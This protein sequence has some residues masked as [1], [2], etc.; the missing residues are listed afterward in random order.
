MA[1][2]AAGTQPER[3]LDGSERDRQLERM[4]VDMEPA[5]SP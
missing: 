1:Y 5:A 3:V 2:Q 4:T